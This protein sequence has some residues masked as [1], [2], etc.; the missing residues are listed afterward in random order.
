MIVVTFHLNISN[1]AKPNGSNL[2]HLKK[3]YYIK[4]K[5]NYNSLPTVI[6]ALQKK[7][8]W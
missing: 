6:K 7:S 2:T 5:I 3:V 4:N 8:S 1:L